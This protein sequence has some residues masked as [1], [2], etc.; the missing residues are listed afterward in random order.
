MP[1][2]DT[3]DVAK[4]TGGGWPQLVVA[5]APVDAPAELD[6]EKGGDASA[7]LRRAMAPSAD[8]KRKEERGG[9]D[10]RMVP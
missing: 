10:G 2:W 4:Y 7:R 3:A 1:V 6:E 9:E 5:T 8:S